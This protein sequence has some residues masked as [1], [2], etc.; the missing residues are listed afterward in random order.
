MNDLRK[1]INIISEAQPP[2]KKT[3]IDLVKSTNDEPLLQKVLKTLKAGNIDERIVKV[4]GKDPDASKFVDKIANIILNMDAPIEE[5]NA[6]LDKFAAGAGVIDAVMLTDGKAH[7]FLEVCGGSAFTKD[8]FVILS[9][10]L[11]SQGVG[12]GEVALA[13]FHPDIAWS[14]RAQGGGDVQIGS[15]AVEVKTSVSSGGR[16][17]NARKARLDMAGI[18]KAIIDADRIVYTKFYKQKNPMPRGL[19]ARLSI[20]EWVN[21]IRPDLV[22]MPEVLADCAKKMA[23]GLFNQVPNDVYA[24]ALES[25]NAMQIKDAILKVG[26]AN[27]KKYSGFDGILMMDVRSEGLQYFTKYTEMAGKVKVDSAYLYAPESEAMPKVKLLPLGGG[28]AAGGDTETD[29]VGTAPTKPV[30]KPVAKPK[31]AG[32]SLSADRIKRPDSLKFPEPGPA[33]VAS[34]QKR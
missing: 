33:P 16:W 9:T 23:T 28:A 29:N 27:Y 22:H 32:T 34:R 19:P 17:V 10:T 2:I 4:I 6:F 5:K 26:F 3:V 8:L 7:T 14:G 13:V 24:K 21:K 18:E 20:D 30:A 12:P 15:K 31:A 25:G 11:V 1:L